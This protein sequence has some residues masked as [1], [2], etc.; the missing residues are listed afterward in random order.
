M[1]FHA[2]ESKESRSAWQQ[3]K[4]QSSSLEP[5]A[6]TS[7]NCGRARSAPR[8]RQAERLDQSSAIYSAVCPESIYPCHFKPLHSIDLCDPVTCQ[9]F[10]QPAALDPSTKCQVADV[11]GPMQNPITNG[12]HHRSM[13]SHTNSPGCRHPPLFSTSEA[14]PFTRR[15]GQ[16]AHDRLGRAILAESALRRGIG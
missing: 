11:A 15:S 13:P 5:R 3:Q 9:T 7:I 1:G 4:Q 12:C 16:N 8:Q 6:S 14:S 2:S 10:W